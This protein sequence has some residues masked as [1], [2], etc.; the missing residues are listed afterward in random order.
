MW[1]F[2]QIY[3]VVRKFIR[4]FA[5]SFKLKVRG[6][7]YK[8]KVRVAS[9]SDKI[10]VDYGLR[11]RIMELFDTSYPTVRAALNGS[12]STEFRRRIRRYALMNGG[13]RVISAGESDAGEDTRVPTRTPALIQIL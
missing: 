5:A 1:I 2:I 12:D 13:I 7:R 8:N 11:V 10:I 4:I 6:Q 3:F 9:M